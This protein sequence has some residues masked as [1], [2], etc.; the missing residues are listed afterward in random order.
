MPAQIIDGDTILLANVGSV[1]LLGVDAPEPD[2][3][4]GPEARGKLIATIGDQPVCVRWKRR[5]RDGMPVRGSYGRLPAR[6]STGRVAGN[7]TWSCRK[8]SRARS[9]KRF[10]RAMSSS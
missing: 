2:E 8:V 1:R 9:M 7:Y 5:K 4:G 6:I 10:M 3:T